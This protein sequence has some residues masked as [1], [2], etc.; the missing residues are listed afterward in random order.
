MARV[1]TAPEMFPDKHPE[2]S[3]FLAGA[4]DMG[5]AVDWQTWVIERLAD[6]A[7]IVLFNPRRVA[8]TPDTLDEQIRW[9][10]EA[11]EHVDTVF[12]WFPKDAKAPISFF[13]SGL[14]W[15]SGKLLV[16]AE[17]G[18]YRRRNLELTGARYGVIVHETLESMVFSLLHT[19]RSVGYLV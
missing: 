16:G 17:L 15:H 2:W 18:F 5:A 4:I 14:Y 3:V 1:I 7:N 9:E 10:L 6:H 8:F 13:E 19:M 11:L 12:M